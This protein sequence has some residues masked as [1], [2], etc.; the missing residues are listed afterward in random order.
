M[1][2]LACSLTSGGK[3]HESKQEEEEWEEVGG[4]ICKESSSASSCMHY[5]SKCIEGKRSRGT[6]GIDA[7]ERG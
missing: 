6:G 5:L 2:V 1:E 3:Q 7:R 4:D